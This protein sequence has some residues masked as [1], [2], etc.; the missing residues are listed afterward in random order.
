MESRIDV[1]KE[2]VHTLLSS[3]ILTFTKSEVPRVPGLYVIYDD[4]PSIN[5][6]GKTNN[7]RRRIL[8]NHRSGNTRGSAFRK[9]LMVDKG[10]RNENEVS[11]F[12]RTSCTFQFLP[13]D[14]GLSAVEH[15]AIAVLNPKLNR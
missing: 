7:L 11:D 8:G 6:V 15:F 3:P 5:Y 10:F 9:A 4:K 14:E 2:S 1:L 13:V 12:I